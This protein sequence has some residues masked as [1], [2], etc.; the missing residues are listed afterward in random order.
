MSRCLA[1]VKSV[2]AFMAAFAVVTGSRSARADDAAVCIAASESEV[3]LKKQEHLKDA[4]KQLVI[5]SS[6]RC[7]AEVKDECER[8][9][10][11]LNAAIP[12]IVL[13]ASDGAGNDLSAV[14]VTLD[15]A[16]LAS[17]LD[18]SAVAVDPGP[19]ALHFEAAGRAPLDKTFV[20]KENEKGRRIDVVLTSRGGASG[21]AVAATS[22]SSW[23]T[24]KTLA[25]ASAGVGVAGVAVGA[26]FGVMAGSDASSQHAA[27]GSSGCPDHTGAVSDHSSSITAGNVSTAMFIVGGVGLAGAAVLWFT[28]P[29]ARVEGGAAARLDSLRVTPLVGGG[30]YGLGALGRFE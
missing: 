18:G 9:A 29:K 19:H 7:P 28:A 12:T 16:P 4:L 22:T 25:L 13:G 27:C 20:A 1:G 6:S 5:C 23:S 26:A 17:A 30:I 10:A 11:R 21:P 2:A 3:A 24:Q 8:R 14:K 15:G